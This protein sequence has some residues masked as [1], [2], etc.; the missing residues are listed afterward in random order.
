M[1]TQ[2]ATE[3]FAVT[4]QDAA[5]T[6]MDTCLDFAR[7]YGGEVDEYFSV[8]CMTFVKAYLG[9]T[10]DHTKSSFKT[11]IRT[12]VWFQLLDDMRTRLGRNNR[13]P[14]VDADLDKHPTQE[15]S[16]DLDEFLETLSE[17]A[18]T[19]IQLVVDTPPAFALEV[20]VRGEF[21]PG[22]V[23]RSLRIF[24]RDLGWASAR[25]VEAFE[26]VRQALGG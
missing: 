14:R 26:E 24:L 5:P 1:P 6:I 17:D 10:F 3:A 2:F 8:G 23:L 19:V 9:D 18:Q 16:F 11:W 13:L 7:K 4:F 25:I 21:T 20:Y 22:N 15:G 12:K